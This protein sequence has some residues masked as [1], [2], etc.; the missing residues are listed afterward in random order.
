[1]AS[2]VKVPDTVVASKAFTIGTRSYAA[3]DTV[4]VSSLP[5]H[6]VTQLLQQRYLRPSNNPG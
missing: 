5:T 3:G 4:D 1:M 6:K 2:A